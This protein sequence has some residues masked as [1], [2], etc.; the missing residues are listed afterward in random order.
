MKSEIAFVDDEIAKCASIEAYNAILEA[1]NDLIKPFG[2]I[3]IDVIPVGF[4]QY[5]IN[6][7]AIYYF[8]EAVVKITPTSKITVW[9]GDKSEFNLAESKLKS[10][11]VEDN[12]VSVVDYM[13]KTALKDMEVGDNH[14]AYRLNASG[15][16]KIEFWMKTWRNTWDVEEE[17]DSRSQAMVEVKIINWK[18]D[19]FWHKYETTYQIE[20]VDFVVDKPD[21]LPY[22]HMECNGGTY[23]YDPYVME[24][25]TVYNWYYDSGSNEDEE[26]IKYWY[27]GDEIQNN[28]IT[29]PHFITYGGQATNRGIG[30]VWATLP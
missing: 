5:I 13:G 30:E 28:T 22:Q 8:G 12:N 14:Y 24:T 11:N 9:N 29:M 20:D 27:I 15:T 2:E 6:R 7:E 17:C 21:E 3:Y 16:R 1:N 4:Y 23:H 26:Y 25:H 18:K 19:V 10:M